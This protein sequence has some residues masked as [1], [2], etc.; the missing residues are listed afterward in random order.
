[1]ADDLAGGDTR[2]RLGLE[3]VCDTVDS[4]IESSSSLICAMLAASS[5]LVTQ[6]GVGP[7]MYCAPGT[8]SN[9]FMRCGLNDNARFVTN[10]H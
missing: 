5:G 8:M 1:M 6:L 2:G 10:N 3:R 9:V 7:T 4:D